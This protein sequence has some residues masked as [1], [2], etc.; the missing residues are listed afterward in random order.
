MTLYSPGNR[1]LFFCDPY[2]SLLCYVMH[3]YLYKIQ[4]IK[5]KISA[6]RTMHMTFIKSREAN[7]VCFEETFAIR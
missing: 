4:I 7:K 6:K 2:A 3:H 5:D 1:L